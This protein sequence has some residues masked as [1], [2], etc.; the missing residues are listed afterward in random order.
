LD[1]THRVARE[2][3]HDFLVEYRSRSHKLIL[4]QRS[5]CEGRR[6]SQDVT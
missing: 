3:K 2:G 5:Y 1:L 6:G 4:M